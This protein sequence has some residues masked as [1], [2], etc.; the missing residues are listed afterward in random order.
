MKKEANYNGNKAHSSIV[1]TI[2]EIENELGVSRKVAT[3]WAQQYLHYKRIGRRYLFSR[4]EFE[5]TFA[6]KEDLTYDIQY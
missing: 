1:I 3:A 2:A 5:E 6:L 4:K